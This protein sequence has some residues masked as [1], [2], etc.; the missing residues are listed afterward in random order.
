MA[1]LAIIVANL[2]TYILPLG[3]IETRFG[4]ST[5]SLVSLV[6]FHA[7]LKAQAPL[8]GVLTLADRIMIG[9]YLMVLSSLLLSSLLITLH[10]TTTKDG[11]PHPMG[12]SLARTI[13]ENTRL[14][15]PLLSL[16]L[17]FGATVA[18]LPTTLLVGASAALL[19]G[20]CLLTTL[21]SLLG[22]YLPHL[23]RPT[24]SRAS[25]SGARY[26]RMA[27][28][29]SAPIV[30][31]N[32][33]LGLTALGLAAPSPEYSTPDGAERS[34][35]SPPETTTRCDTRPMTPLPEEPIAWAASHAVPSADSLARPADRTRPTT[36]PTPATGT[37][38]G[39]GAGAGI[40][41]ECSGAH[42]CH[43][44]ELA[45]AEGFGRQ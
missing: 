29:D 9:C 13:F 18:H 25:H 31:P 2:F 6:L 38:A 24:P 23:P 26:R 15:G 37:G 41:L 32:T 4:L 19:L 10:F 16:L 40:R 42:E 7:G 44:T 21:R 5:S 39:T 22:R 20:C 12:R 28:P 14:L 1:P 45:V 43:E 27:Q 33:A 3:V 36:A 11:S 17:F 30:T 35:R 34:R 8:A